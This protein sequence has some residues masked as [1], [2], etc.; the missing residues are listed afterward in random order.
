MTDPETKERLLRW[1][2][3]MKEARPKFWAL[4]SPRMM[5]RKPIITSKEDKVMRD[6]KL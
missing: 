6:F 1:Y 5:K 2:K 4:V 3:Y